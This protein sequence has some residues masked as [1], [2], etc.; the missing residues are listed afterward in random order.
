MLI[1]LTSI[2]VATTAEVDA[3]T[4]AA[5]AQ[6]GNAALE[7]GQTAGL[8]KSL[9]QP[10]VSPPKDESPDAI[11][12]VSNPVQNPSQPAAQGPMVQITQEPIGDSPTLGHPTFIGNAAWVTPGTLVNLGN[13]VWQKIQPQTY[14]DPFQKE[15]D[16]MKML[17][18]P[19]AIHSRF[20]TRS[21]LILAITFTIK[22]TSHSQIIIIWEV[23][24]PTFKLQ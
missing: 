21:S 13:T 6:R 11:N 23:V 2:G 15:F 9:S 4:I 19:P 22:R 18:K 24:P 1:P 14:V 5:A 3:A 20:S 12:P 16:E 8:P 7:A 10:I 17:K